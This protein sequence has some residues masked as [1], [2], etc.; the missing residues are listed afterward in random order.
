MLK[1]PSLK[2]EDVYRYHLKMNQEKVVV[3][4]EVSMWH[5][6]KLY[7][8]Q[9]NYLV[10]MASLLEAKP[11]SIVCIS[12]LF[13]LFYLLIDIDGANKLVTWLLANKKFC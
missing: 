1:S 9:K 12:L 5:L 10:L 7:Y 3:W 2:F 4:Q 8:H 11:C 6:H 13:I